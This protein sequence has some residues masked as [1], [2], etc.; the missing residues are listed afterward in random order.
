M[1]ILFAYLHHLCAFTI[2]AVLVAEHLLLIDPLTLPTARK[3]L[4]LDLIYGIAAGLLLAIGFT[5]VFLFEKGPAYY[6]HSAPYLIKMGLFLCVGLISIYPT[7]HFLGWR[8]AVAA[9]QTPELKPQTQKKLMM[10]LRLELLG[11]V[12]ILLCAAMMA[13]GV[14]YFG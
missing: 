3:L 8:K 6:F 1:P 4:T 7:V 12:L 10:A 2:F 13:K 11:V 9:G 5:R 14:G